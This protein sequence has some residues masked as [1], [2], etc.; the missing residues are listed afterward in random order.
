MFFRL[1]GIITLLIHV[2]GGLLYVIRQF[3]AIGMRKIR[4]EMQ[5]AGIHIKMLQ[6]EF[7]DGD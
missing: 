6:K 2:I 3:E 4:I 7:I 5:N 1:S